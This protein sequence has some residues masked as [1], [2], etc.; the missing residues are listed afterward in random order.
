MPVPAP[1]NGGA[2]GERPGSTQGWAPTMPSALQTQARIAF[3]VQWEDDGQDHPGG[4]EGRASWTSWLCWRRPCVRACVGVGGLVQRAKDT[5]D[6]VPSRPWVRAAVSEDP[7][8]RGRMRP[9]RPF[10]APHSSHP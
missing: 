7:W 1:R 5:D 6:N 4:R 3:Q 9:F 10:P 2:L 8:G